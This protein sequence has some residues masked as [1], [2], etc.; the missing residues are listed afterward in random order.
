MCWALAASL[1]GALLARQFN[2]PGGAFTGAMLLTAVVSVAGLRM[3]QPPRWMAV[4]SRIALGVTT[5]AAVTSETVQAVAR[6][7]L[8]VSLMVV[9]LM[10]I[11]L[12]TA[13][14]LNRWAHMDLPTALCGAAPGALAAMVALA[15]DLKGDAPTV[16]SLHLVRLVSVLIFMPLLVT[17]AFTPATQPGTTLAVV[18]MEPQAR[19]LRLAVLLLAGLLAGFLAER[20]KAPAGDFLA[21]MVVAAALN[22]TLL[23]LAEM[24]FAWKLFAQWVVGASVGASVTRETL[25]HFKPYAVSGALMTVFLIVI[26]LILG[27]LLSIISGLDLLTCIMGTAPG[28]ATSL[29]ILAEELGADAQLVSAM[30]VSRIVIIML[31]LPLLV[32]SASVRRTSRA[33]RE[34]RPEAIS[35]Q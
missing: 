30:H 29:V 18:S 35:A 23:H 27:W 26:G 31:L 5:G 11:G 9:S 4:A 2:I 8:P 17:S 7:L 25:R 28:G 24:P 14:A 12:V 22:P 15:D 34:P 10:L 1:V 32:R 16:A 6:A 33:R 20:H 19:A 21:G 3:E 13:W